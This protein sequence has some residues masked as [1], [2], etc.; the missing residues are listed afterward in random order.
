M[1]AETFH[2]DSATISAPSRRDDHPASEEY[3]VPGAD[4]AAIQADIPATLGRD[5]GMVRAALDHLARLA[6]KPLAELDP[7][8][9]TRGCPGIPCHR[10]GGGRRSSASCCKCYYRDDRVCARWAMSSARRFRK[11]IRWSRATGRCSI[12]PKARP[13]SLRR[14]P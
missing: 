5:T 10:R 4:D 1:P 14:A 2:K 12:P 3:N 13:P 6:G 11:A 7:A 8:K 9:R